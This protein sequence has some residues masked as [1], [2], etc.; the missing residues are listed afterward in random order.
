MM[1]KLENFINAEPITMETNAGETPA[2]VLS[3][4]DAES[5]IIDRAISLQ[6]ARDIVTDL[7]DVLSFLGDPT[8]RRLGKD[9]VRYIEMDEDESEVDEE[10]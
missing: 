5:A 4:G 6:D 3:F 9:L 10:N 2:I 8:A 1:V 7:L